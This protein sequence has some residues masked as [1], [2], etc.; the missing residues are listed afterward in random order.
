MEP[1]SF[2]PSTKPS[3]PDP[4]F[5]FRGHAQAAAREHGEHREPEHGDEG[6]PGA[7]DLGEARLKTCGVGFLKLPLFLVGVEGSQKENHTSCF[8]LACLVLRVPLDLW[9]E[10]KTKRKPPIWRVP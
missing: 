5:A 10:R 3:R 6:V 9:L 1:S 7:T 4:A 2:G 8:F